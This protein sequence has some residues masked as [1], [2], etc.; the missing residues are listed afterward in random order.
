MNE[1]VKLVSCKYVSDDIGNQVPELTE[2]EIFCET[3]SVSQ[4]EFF[5]GAQAGLKPEYKFKILA[6]EYKG[7]TLVQYKN[8]LYSV[9]RT[10]NVNDFTELY[11]TKKVGD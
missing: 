6:D 5:H 2:R 11:V 4:T 8:V 7:E 3:M 1:L 10:Y 9:Y